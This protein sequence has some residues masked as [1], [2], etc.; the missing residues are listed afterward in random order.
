M[1]VLP[2]FDRRSVAWALFQAVGWGLWL[3]LV[4]WKLTSVP[5]LHMDEAWSIISARGQWEP[6][7]PF[8]GM[9]AYSGA[10][11]RW[12]LMLTGTR[13]GVAVLRVTSVLANG[14]ALV[15]S[16]LVLRRLYPREALRGWALPLLATTPIWLVTARHALEVLSFTPLLCFLSLY[17]LLRQRPWAA[18]GAGV[19]WGLLIYN[20]LIGACFPLSIALS[21]LVVYRKKPPVALGPLCLGFLVGL[22][23]R[24]VAVALY[25]DRALEGS[26]AQYSFLRAAGD[27]EWLPRVLWDTLH[28]RTVFLRYVGFIAVR[29]WPYWLVSLLLLIPVLQKPHALPRPAL[30]S[31]LAA[32]GFAVAGTLEA[33]YMAVRFLV[34]PAIGVSMGAAMLGAAA[35][36]RDSRWSKLVYLTAVV[37]V[38][39]NLFYL[40]ADFYV[41]WQNRDFRLAHFFLGERSP[42]TTSEGFLP[43]EELVRYLRALSPPPEQII[44]PSTIGRPL[45]ALLGDTG[46][47][48]L[49]PMAATNRR[50][51]TVYVDYTS[52]GVP[53]SWC[54]GTGGGK[55]CFR[56]V[57]KVDKNY[58]VCR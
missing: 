12:L 7:N 47:P 54:V 5:G 20:H 17:L 16:G 22:A 29:V 43:K 3:A 48:V 15:L 42:R 31:L 18:F 10:F 50:L 9:T 6:E 55:M 19:S 45:R 34:M 27:L 41:P 21:W 35:I 37:L 30:M 25:H 13:H 38:A 4:G 51:R 40:T 49:D 52:G 56:H 14:T 11:P 53:K 33:P 1:P 36:V 2:R 57:E 32:L 58:L 28:G 26:G 8:S 44:A 39:C 24:L 23:P 46:I